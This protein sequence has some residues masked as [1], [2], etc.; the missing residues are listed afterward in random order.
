M[1]LPR[2]RFTLRRMTL[3][4]A[5]LGISFAIY[6]T[7]TYEVGPEEAIRIATD[8]LLRSDKSFRPTG[9]MARAYRTCG[10]APWTVDFFPADSRYLVRIVIVSQS[11]S[12]GQIMAFK[13]SDHCVSNERFQDVDAV[14]LSRSQ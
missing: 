13:E 10:N 4:V 6:R 1:R 9:T 11:G 12:V 8:N 2:V 14:P 5:I 3:A 7:A